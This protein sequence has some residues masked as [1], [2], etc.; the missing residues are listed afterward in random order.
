MEKKH[1]LKQMDIHFKKK[2]IE[3][4][5]KVNDFKRDLKEKK[6]YYEWKRNIIEKNQKERGKRD[7]EETLSSKYNKIDN[8][9]LSKRDLVTNKKERYFRS[10]EQLQ[11]EI[12]KELQTKARKAERIRQ[13]RKKGRLK[14][15]KFIKEKYEKTQK[16]LREDK[17][18][19]KERIDFAK[20][21]AERCINYEMKMMK[22]LEQADE[23]HQQIDH[24]F[25]GIG[26]VPFKPKPTI[27]ELKF[28]GFQEEGSKIEIPEEE[29]SKD[30]EKIDEEAFSKILERDNEKW[31]SKFVGL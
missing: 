12:I 28:T 6:A 17:K 13:E 31:V 5:N 29:G 27:M 21:K 10:V 25:S 3:E 19:E 22:E 20:K 14:R 24:Q 7:R 15:I 16:R 11:R 2:V 30:E 1:F 26:D 4:K 9:F 18:K 23:I 8:M